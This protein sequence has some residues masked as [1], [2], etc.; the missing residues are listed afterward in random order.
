M[1]FVHNSEWVLKQKDSHVFMA[2]FQ[3]ILFHF[4]V[5]YVDCEHAFR[6][7]SIINSNTWDLGFF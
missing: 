3:H 7:S 1:K 6:G 4:S 2:N 5:F